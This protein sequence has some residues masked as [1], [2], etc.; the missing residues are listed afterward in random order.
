MSRRTY[1][2]FIVMLTAFAA[3]PARAQIPF[4]RDLVPTRSALARA[5]LE[6]QWMAVVPLSA[7]ERLHLISLNDGLLFAQTNKGY[8]HTFDAE[9]GRLLWTARLS[10]Q[11]ARSRPASVN[12]FGV[13][14]TAF[15]RLFALDRRTGRTIWSVELRSLPSSSTSCDEDRVFVGLNNGKIYGYNLKVKDENGANE[16]ISETPIE[17]WN[18]QTSGVIESKPLPAQKLVAFGSDD[19][20]V[21]VSL[22]DERTMLYRIATG[23]PI[24]VGLGSY[25][26]RLLLIPSADRILYGVDVLT[27]KMR[28]TFASGAPIRQEPLVAD[29]DVFVVNEA[30]QMSSIDPESGSPRWSVSTHG[31][32][33]LAVGAK[34]VYLE[35]SDDDL[36]IIDRATG[37]TVAS[38]GTTLERYGLNIR[39][40]ELGITNR[41]TD[42]LY[43][44]T[45]SGMVV[46][47]RE[48]GLT[49]PRFL[50]D[51]KA[52]PF[53]TI[54]REG[55]RN[56]LIK[57][58]SPLSPGAE[59][60]PAEGEKPPAPDQPK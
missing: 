15:N 6:Q 33:L 53:G 37:Q 22:S 14:V 44:A 55:L 52:L 36:F 17:V 54:P 8:F 19:G 47:V 2:T 3:L 35:S 27:A 11:I 43:F 5:G 60:I 13:F 32:R 18:W 9:T 48:I 23:G 16:R 46:A 4:P 31:G 10:N 51:P 29:D 45:T 28:W 34:R 12:S 40:Y 21:Y 49:K 42:R 1:L 59:T 56:E 20:K 38:A 24:G 57:L 50:R 26:T 39:P 58:E 7:S 30:G 25:G 41:E